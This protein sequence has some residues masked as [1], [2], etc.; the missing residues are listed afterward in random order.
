MQIKRGGL[1]G[2]VIDHLATGSHQQALPSS[3]AP[4]APRVPVPP[5][6][7]IPRLALEADVASA[8]ALQV[9]P[10]APHAPPVGTLDIGS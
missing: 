9:P 2:K 7:D 4:H 1:G 10:I 3:V 6:R 5:S 8:A